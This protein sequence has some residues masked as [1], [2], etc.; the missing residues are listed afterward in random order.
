MEHTECPAIDE[1]LL[2]W[3]EATYPNQLPRDHA[4]DMT[5]VLF[6]AGQVSIIRRLRM[7]YHEQT[8]PTREE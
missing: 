5:S 8:N 1:V 6:R 3:L 4:E 2:K 7:E